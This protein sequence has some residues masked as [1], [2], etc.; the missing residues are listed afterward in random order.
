MIEVGFIILPSSTS[1]TISSTIS[2]S[3]HYDLPIN[4]PSHEEK[5]ND[6][7]DQENEMI[8]IDIRWLEEDEKGEEEMM[9]VNEIKLIIS[10]FL[11]FFDHQNQQQENE[12]KI[13]RKS[14]LLHIIISSS[15]STIS[16]YHNNLLFLPSSSTNFSNHQNNFQSSSS[17]S[18]IKFSNEINEIFFH[19]IFSYHI[20]K[21]LLTLSSQNLPS[22]NNHE[23]VSEMTI[24]HISSIS[25][26][27]FKNSSFVWKNDEMRDEDDFNYHEIVENEHISH[28]HQPSLPIFEMIKWRDEMMKFLCLQIDLSD[29]LSITNQQ[30]SNNDEKLDLLS[31]HQQLS[32]LP[33][34]SLNHQNNYFPSYDDHFS[35]FYKLLLKYDQK[36]RN[37]QNLSSN[38]SILCVS[39]STISSTNHQ[40]SSSS[41]NKDM[42][43]ID[44][45]LVRSNLSHFIFFCFFIDF[46]FKSK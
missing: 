10:S 2:S 46:F 33:S 26:I 44:L 17:S 12:I 18:L 11:K 4:L 39:Q 1:T 45:E 23:M 3:S 38:K 28:N 9:M 19:F 8:K 20:L 22:H 13:N 5:E 7:N 15:I 43:K 37:D 6:E 16:S 36:R 31:P 41:K 29:D 25:S 24:F 14:I 40:F 30:Q 21:I 42:L 35:I 27:L 32:H 34:S